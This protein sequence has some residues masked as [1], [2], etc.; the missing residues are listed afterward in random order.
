MITKE[1]NEFTTSDGVKLHFL[2]KGKGQPI[3]IIP[4]WSQTAE[5]Y[6][7][8]LE[9][10]CEKYQ[11][12]VIDMRGHG[13]SE[14]VNF[15]YRIARFS[16]DLHEFLITRSL[17]NVILIGHSIGACVSWSYW[18]L[19]G[20][21]YLAKM[22]FVD[23]PVMMV[24][25]PGWSSSEI[26][27]FGAL[28]TASSAMDIVDSV[29]TGKENFKLVT[30]NRMLS[31]NVSPADKQSLLHSSYLL[32]SEQS[33]RLLYSFFFQDWRDVIPR[34]DLPCL[35]I[36]GRASTTSISSQQWLHQQIKGS[37]LII[38]EEDE[39]GKHFMFYENPI[40]FNHIVDTFI[41]GV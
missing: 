40:K 5:Q 41:Q 24:A 13:Q 15:G 1:H 4:G 7:G 17:K 22:I 16:K 9:G 30:L 32:P 39:G 35:I 8:Q 33:A 26:E 3:V 14:K 23:Q 27:N 2:V 10:L 37:Q 25:N 6:R 34:I 21:E 29:Q 11:V 28:A 38:F 31:E 36:C 12:F 20:K 18:D 19:F